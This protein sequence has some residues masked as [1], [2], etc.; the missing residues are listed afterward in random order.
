LLGIKDRKGSL[1]VGK[2]ADIVLLEPN[3]DAYATIV[4]GKI[5]YRR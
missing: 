3:G 1:A 2:D 4:G 5:A